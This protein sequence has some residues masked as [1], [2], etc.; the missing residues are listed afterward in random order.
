MSWSSVNSVKVVLANVIGFTSGMADFNCS[1]AANS[2]GDSN[3]NSSI[4]VTTP[5]SGCMVTVDRPE[6]ELLHPLA[7]DVAVSCLLSLMIV[8]T[9][10]GNCLVVIAVTRY[11]R[12][13]DNVT[14][15]FVLSLAIADLFVALLVMPFA[16]LIELTAGRWPLGMHFC[17]LWISCDVTCCTASILHLC[18]ISLDRYL[19]ITR[20]LTYHR[21]MS[22]AR[23]RTLVCIA[24]A[25]SAAISFVPIHLDWYADDV[26]SALDGRCGLYVNRLYA[27]ISSS[28][29]FYLPLIIMSCAYVKIYRIARSQVKRIQEITPHH[30]NQFAGG[31][32]KTKK[33]WK[34][35]KTLGVMMGLFCL[36]W[37]PFFLVYLTEPFC[38]ADGAT[39]T[40]R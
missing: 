37:L 9:I 23:A 3:H 30:H 36:C 33:D 32:R 19:A 40:S 4:N 26:G 21:D 25:C 28:L 11:H 6:D 24:W 8:T 7:R 1:N 12:L 39:E 38:R 27:V 22:R 18:L 35:L 2:S 13:R 31:G 14:N 5:P 29:S 17:R 10:T 16:V 34:A 15:T 20:P